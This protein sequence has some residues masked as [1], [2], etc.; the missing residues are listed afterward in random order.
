[1]FDLISA[2]KFVRVN[3]SIVSENT[4]KALLKNVGGN[5][6]VKP[7]LTQWSQITFQLK[8]YFRSSSGSEIRCVKSINFF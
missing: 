4:L 5:P 3:L 2:L 8:I 1:M 7:V 6:A